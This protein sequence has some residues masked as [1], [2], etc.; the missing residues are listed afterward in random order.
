MSDLRDELEHLRHEVG[1][2]I[3]AMVHAPTL[4][5]VSHLLAA[6]AAVV[7]AVMLVLQ[8]AGQAQ[9]AASV[10]YGSGLA[11]A[12]GTSGVYHRMR[13][14]P[15][16]ARI[17]RTLDHSMIFVLVASSYTPFLLIAI[18]GGW[19]VALLVLVWVLA[20]GGVILRLAVPNMP[21]AAMA[22]LYLGLGWTAL[23]MLP[24]LYGSLSP[25]TFQLL[26]IGGVLYTLGALVYIV[27]RPDP[28]PR[29]FGF[30][31]VFHVFVVAAAACHYAA[32]WPLVTAPV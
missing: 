18:D 29:T 16:A 15:R 25:G 13:T 7:G 28:L 9:L 26:V 22:G 11:L 1:E 3:E 20:S 5:G 6:V 30:H 8:A 19:R 21:R 2:R 23:A 24:K 12:L 31:E 17:L 32:V 4:R 14:R 27:R 10:V